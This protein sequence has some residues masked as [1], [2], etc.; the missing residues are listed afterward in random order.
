VDKPSEQKVP[1]RDN[2]K[3]HP[4]K[5]V[6]EVGCNAG[7]NLYLLAKKFAEVNIYGVDINQ[8]SVRVGNAWFAEKGFKNIK[9]FVGKA[10]DLKMFEDNSVDFIFTN[11]VL[12]V[13]RRNKIE[14]V[15][16]EMIRI[17]R[18]GLIFMEWHCFDVQDP[19]NNHAHALGVYHEGFW[20]RDYIALL[21]RFV[22]REQLAVTKIPVDIW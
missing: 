11:A 5:S 20:K 2:L 15:I 7:P 21:S 12:V 18:R 16:S 19:Q 8:N 4:F 6:C 1:S 13:I 22:Q 3:S 10:D 9:L 14:Q 17:A